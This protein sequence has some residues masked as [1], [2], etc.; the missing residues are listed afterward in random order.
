MTEKEPT[1]GKKCDLMML[2]NTEDIRNN[3][4]NLPQNYHK[5]LRANSNASFVFCHKDFSIT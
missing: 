3:A 1:K 2:V 4:A 5:K